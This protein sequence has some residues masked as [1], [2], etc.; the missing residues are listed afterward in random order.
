MEQIQGLS[1]QKLQ[2]VGVIVN[3]TG[4]VN[5]LIASTSHVQP[6]FFF[7]LVRVLQPRRVS[8]FS[9]VWLEHQLRRLTLCNVS[10]YWSANHRSLKERW[11]SPVLILSFYFSARSSL[12][13]FTQ[14][15]L[16]YYLSANIQIT[17]LYQCSGLCRYIDNS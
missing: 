1:L 12:C 3:L 5:V 10:P 8:F 17:F 6:P 15:T 13:R 11:I 7:C 14:C 9:F 16:Q 4:P 2:S